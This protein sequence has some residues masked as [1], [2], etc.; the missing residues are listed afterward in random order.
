[1]IPRG[2]RRPTMGRGRREK[3]GNGEVERGPSREAQMGSGGGRDL[4]RVNAAANHSG[5][6]SSTGN[7]MDRIGT[8]GIRTTIAGR[9]S[10]MG[11]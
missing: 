8:G 6:T 7:Q 1:M 11:Q 3:V 10:L 5:Q 2:L 9:S 4:G